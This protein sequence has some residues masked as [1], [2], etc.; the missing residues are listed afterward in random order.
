MSAEV[1]Y[2][3]Q[4]TSDDEVEYV[5]REREHAEEYVK[6]FDGVGTG[7]SF[8]IMEGIVWESIYDI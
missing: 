8:R 3:V 2:I 4:E 6:Q 5:F 1:V 7:Y